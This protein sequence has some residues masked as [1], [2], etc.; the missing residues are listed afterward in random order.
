MGCVD[1][2]VAA[3]HVERAREFVRG[4][5]GAFPRMNLT[6]ASMEDLRHLNHDLVF[7]ASPM[8]AGGEPLYPELKRVLPGSKIVFD[9]VY[10]PKETALLAEAK[11][12]GSKGG[13]EVTVNGKRWGP[14]LA[15]ETARRAIRSAG[16]DP[17]AFSGKVRTTSTIPVG[18]GLKTSS[19]SS[20]AI[21]LAVHAALGKRTVDP[22]RVLDCSV[23][24]SLAS[25]ASVTGALDDA[26]G[27]LLGGIDRKSVV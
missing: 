2:A 8:G 19:S 6:L 13:W 17:D 5:E 10:R 25:G 16:K 22:K 1:V 14:G 18:V 11:R 4:M 3:R 12:N 23:D 20:T 7:N 26:A 21:A 15:I 9:A 27:C 24:A